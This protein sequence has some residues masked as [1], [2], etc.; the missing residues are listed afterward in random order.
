MENQSGR[1]DILGKFILEKYQTV[2]WFS[3]IATI[4]LA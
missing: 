3:I 4:A 2:F 1:T